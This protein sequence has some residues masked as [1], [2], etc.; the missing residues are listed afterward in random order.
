[1]QRL[2]LRQSDLALR[3]LGLSDAKVLIQA[4][5]RHC[6]DGHAQVAEVLRGE[7]RARWPLQEASAMV[8]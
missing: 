8:D 3:R 5:C 6:D 2:G 7:D 1:M 4:D